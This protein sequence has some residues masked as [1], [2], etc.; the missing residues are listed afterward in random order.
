MRHVECVGEGEQLALGDGDLGGIAR[1]SGDAEHTL[2]RGPEAC[3]GAGAQDRAGEFEA[4]RDGPA[5]EVLGGLVQTHAD[6]AI[7]VV[8]ADCLGTDHDLSRTGLEVL[9]GVDT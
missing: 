5:D 1:E 6:D 7:C 9:E 8:D 3:A 2:S 4:G